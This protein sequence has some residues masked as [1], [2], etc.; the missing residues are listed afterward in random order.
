MPK[1]K[2]Q[3]RVV[4]K[5]SKKSIKIDSGPLEYGGWKIGDVAWW[6]MTSEATP[7]QGIIA[8]FHPEDNVGP[9]VSLDDTA[10]GRRV[11]LMQFI[12]DTKKAAK[13]SRPEFI[14]FWQNYRNQRDQKK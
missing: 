4:R 12:F 7:H 8:R 10:G 6:C 14:E 1:A 9:A 11:A 2:K 13:A 5:K 3:K